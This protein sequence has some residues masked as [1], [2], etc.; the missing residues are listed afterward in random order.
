MLLL[1]VLGCFGFRSAL[2]VLMMV[3]FSPFFSFRWVLGV[4]RMGASQP[5]ASPQHLSL[6]HQ[7]NC[8]E[9]LMGSSALR[10]MT[11]CQ[12]YISISLK[13]CWICL[14][15]GVRSVHA[16]HILPKQNRKNKSLWTIVCVQRDLDQLHRWAV[17]TINLWH[18]LIGKKHWL[19][20]LWDSLCYGEKGQLHIGSCLCTGLHKGYTIFLGWKNIKR[21]SGVRVVE[22]GSTWSRHTL[23]WPA[24]LPP[25]S[26]RPSLW[27]CL[28]VRQQWE[29]KN[30]GERS[31]IHRA[32]S[33]SDAPQC[34]AASSRARPP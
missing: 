3:I 5:V 21:A 26:S 8:H 9:A 14:E 31:H 2:L 32:I 19:E 10:Y 1:N 27:P 16:R 25:P 24:S 23:P 28:T 7:Q 30:M 34:P 13:S 22:N 6:K 29:D 15:S 12:C 33:Y 11:D 17:A 18:L 20:K 4:E